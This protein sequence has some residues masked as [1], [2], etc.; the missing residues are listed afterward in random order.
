MKEVPLPRPPPSWFRELGLKWD[1]GPVVCDRVLRV[2]ATE[3]PAAPCS[4]WSVGTEIRSRNLADEGRY[5]FLRSGQKKS[6]TGSTRPDPCGKNG[7][8]WN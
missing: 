5:P 8:W 4:G 2:A 7:R 6:D 1:A 3:Y